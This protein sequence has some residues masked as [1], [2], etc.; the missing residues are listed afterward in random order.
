MYYGSNSYSS[1]AL[2]APVVE[3]VPVNSDGEANAY[4]DLVK[5]KLA[6]NRSIHDYDEGLKALISS[7]IAAVEE[8]TRV[9]IQPAQVTVRYAGYDGSPLPFGPVWA[10]PAPVVTPLVDGSTITFS[11]STAAAVG[12]GD[13]PAIGLDF[14]S[15]TAVYTGGYSMLEANSKPVP[16]A[17]IAAVVTHAA[18]SFRAGGITGGKPDD[19][20]KVIAG[21]KR[22]FD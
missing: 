16:D 8:Y 13:Y 15:G 21:P 3:R 18:S 2:T 12:E 22:R 14:S 6:M 5:D 1:Q 9:A 17:L 20:W 19:Y 10:E 7:A 4:I 11:N